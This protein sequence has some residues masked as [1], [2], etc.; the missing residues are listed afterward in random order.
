[1][2]SSSFAR[3]ASVASTTVR[4]VRAAVWRQCPQPY[5]INTP[6]HLSLVTNHRQPLKH[7]DKTISQVYRD[8]FEK[9]DLETLLSEFRLVA[10]E[11]A[12]AAAEVEEDSPT[13]ADPGA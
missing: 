9:L 12:K 8:Q 7:R 3:E 2:E 10:D 4:C 11:K 5:P 1:M 13:S 6:T